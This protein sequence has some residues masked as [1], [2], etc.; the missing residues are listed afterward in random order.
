MKKDHIYRLIKSLDPREQRYFHLQEG[1]YHKEGGSLHYRLFK[2]LLAQEAYDEA[3]LLR[4]LY[5]GQPHAQF[6]VLKNHL[7]HQLLES[8]ITFKGTQHSLDKIDQL[9]RKSRVLQEKKLYVEAGRF[10]ARAAKLAESRDH[11]ERLLIIY[12]QWKQLYAWILEVDK[13]AL[14]IQRFWEKEREV[15]E[16]LTNLREMEWISMR[17][18]DLY[19][20]IHYAG[21][22]AEVALYRE[23]MD[24]PLLKNEELALSFSAKVI[25]LNTHGLYEDA[26][27]RRVSSLLYRK[28]L[29]EL[30]QSR[31][32]LLQEHF[33]QRLAATNNYLLAL[34]HQGDYTE[35]QSA[36][37]QLAELPK[38]FSRRLKPEEDLIWFRTHYSLQLEVHLRQG[39]F[40]EAEKMIPT[41][42]TYFKRLDKALN[43]AFR[44]PFQ[45]FFAYTCFALGKYDQA[46]DFLAPLLHQVELNF[47]QELF[48]FARLLQLIVHF[49]RGDTELLPSL[50][51]S[52]RRYLRKLG[53]LH[54][55]DEV[56]IRFLDKAPFVQRRKAFVELQKELD[57]LPDGTL[58]AQVLHHFHF[59][60]WVESHLRAGAFAEVFQE[61]EKEGC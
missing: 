12:K 52:T 30:Y 61:L 34:I 28:K 37:D 13:R 54:Q 55:L 29:V 58:S 49:E 7:Y 60:A 56:L 26:I 15:L 43:P 32:D 33:T 27:G 36:L 50:L 9:I 3:A 11:F 59:R 14:H 25:Y 35:A 21:N 22:E 17:V 57:D 41:V 18:F 42:Q 1:L 44:F 10:L 20:R 4:E 2:L 51:R 39:K 38:Q 16:Q 6:H 46:L 53:A 5:P 19:Y 8:L 47:R 31:P 23:L 48:R 24:H 40:S 45:Y